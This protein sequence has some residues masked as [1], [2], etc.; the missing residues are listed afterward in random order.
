[1]KKE[2]MIVNSCGCM[3]HLQKSGIVLH[4]KK[5][6]AFLL[7]IHFSLY[8]CELR[9]DAVLWA[10]YGTKIKFRR[11]MQIEAPVACG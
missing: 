10:K 6:P 5:V 3:T 11:S 7:Q 4:G 2:N 9:W 8:M 1:M